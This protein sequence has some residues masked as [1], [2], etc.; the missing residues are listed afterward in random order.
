LSILPGC[1]SPAIGADAI[2]D[3]T[4]VVV[5]TA[6]VTSTSANEQGEQPTVLFRCEDGIIGAY[7]VSDWADSVPSGEH[8]VP[9]ALDSALG[10]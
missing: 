6:A 9:I 8:M 1:S 10:C 7:I 2:S 5:A 4:H 3:T